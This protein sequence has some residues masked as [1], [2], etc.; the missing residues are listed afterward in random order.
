MGN[1]P[2]FDGDR[3]IGI[4]TSGAYGYTVGQSLAFA[5]VESGYASPG[6][7]FEVGILGERRA[8]TVQAEPLY[9]PR[10]ERLRA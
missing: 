6:T 4:T 8:A 1:E 5:Y 2:V 9:D 10:N 3:V 7:T